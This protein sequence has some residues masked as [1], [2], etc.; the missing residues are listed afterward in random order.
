M[1]SS[2]KAALEVLQFILGHVAK[3]VPGK[4]AFGLRQLSFCIRLCT[5]FMFDLVLLQAT[6]VREKE[7]MSVLKCKRKQ[8]PVSGA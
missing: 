6:F 1:R 4:C 3:A 2:L 8:W 5:F 7:I